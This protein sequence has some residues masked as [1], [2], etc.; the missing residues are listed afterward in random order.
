LFVSLTVR[1]CMCVRA[2]LP[3]PIKFNAISDLAHICNVRTEG[4]IVFN[5]LTSFIQ[6]Y[7]CPSISTT[8]ILKTT[9]LF[10]KYGYI[11]RLFLSSPQANMVTEFRYIKCAPNG[12]P[13]RLQNVW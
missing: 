8:I 6:Y 1:V 9:M 11:F 4:L 10:V 13:L 2:C 5:K 7:N 12:I 3:N